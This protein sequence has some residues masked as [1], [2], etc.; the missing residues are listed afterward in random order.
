MK[1]FLFSALVG[2]YAIYAP[3]FSEA[4]Y[5]IKDG[6]LINMH[7]IA[8]MSVQEHYSLLKEAL[9][10]HNFQELIRQANVIIKNFPDSPFAWDAYFYLGEAYF[11]LREFDMANANFAAYL[12]QS[13]P[14]FFEQAIEY[15]F[16]IAQEFEKGEKR[17]LLGI[18]GMPKWMPAS[19]EAIEIYEEVI[20]A[21]PQHDLAVQ[22]LLGKGMLQFK[23]E[24]FKESIE[25]FQTLIRRF[26]KHPLACESYIAITNVYLTQSKKEY[27][28]PDF[29]DL[30]EINVKKF[31]AEFPGH[32]KIA[33]VD[34]MVGKMKELYAGE[35]YKTAQFYERTKKPNAAMIYYSKILSKYP[36]TETSQ[37]SQKRL[38]VL[39]KKAP[40][41]KETPVQ[42]KKSGGVLVE[43]ENEA[44]NQQETLR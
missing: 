44:S 34:E 28:D 5:T 1:R 39:E 18:E 29:L 14:K 8:T 10:N 42:P 16:R 20:M 32:P 38:E 40:K 24:E 37:K 31:K 26:P 17:P 12:K 6:K 36:G 11:H 9:E 7:E 41:K 35:L 3:I 4:A 15:K 30:A 33:L 2:G 25:T 19:H 27:P 13:A 23:E 43:T 22:A 21:L